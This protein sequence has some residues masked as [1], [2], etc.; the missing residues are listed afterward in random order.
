[1]KLLSLILFFLFS[2]FFSQV[3]L[4]EKE[5]WKF[6]KMTLM[7]WV[8]TDFSECIVQLCLCIITFHLFHIITSGQRAI[9]AWDHFFSRLVKWS[10]GILQIHFSS[11]LP[12]LSYYFLNYTRL[13]MWLSFTYDIQWMTMTIL[14]TAQIRNW[15]KRLKVTVTIL[16]KSKFKIK[17]WQLNSMYMY[18]YIY[19]YLL[20]IIYIQVLI[21]IFASFMQKFTF[22]NHFSNGNHGW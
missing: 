16:A 14:S 21:K 15:I 8:S 3:K 6:N 11:H 18:L 4:K 20:I 5:S 19:T 9:I 2:F 22:S 17:I 13:W 7:K 12:H 1:M 10:S